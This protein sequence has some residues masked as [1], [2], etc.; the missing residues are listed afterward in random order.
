M[1]H[2]DI[3]VTVK[4][5]ATLARCMPKDG[6]VRLRQRARVRE[7]LAALGIPE[8]DAGILVVNKK[9]AHMDQVLELSL[10]HI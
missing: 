10:I 9:D 8:E 5:L 2:P 7:L 1:R 6:K 4:L 3:E